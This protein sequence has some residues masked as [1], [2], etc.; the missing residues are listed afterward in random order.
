[1]C[2]AMPSLTLLSLDIFPAQ[3]GLASSCQ[4]FLS[5]GVNTIVSGF[6]AFFWGTT[7]TLALTELAVLI[8]GAVAVFIYIKVMNVNT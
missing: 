5:L 1:M 6:V 7:L 8:L 4:T 3:R 2:T